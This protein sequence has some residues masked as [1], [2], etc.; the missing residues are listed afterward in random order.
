MSSLN[1][2]KPTDISLDIP[3][4]LL[5]QDKGLDFS[6]LKGKKLVGLLG[7]A[8]SGKDTVADYF[9]DNYGYK[10]IKFGDILKNTLN[11]YFREIVLEDLVNRNIPISF[12]EI[13]FLVEDDRIL[14]EKLRPYM[15]WLGETLRE[16]NGVHF[17]INK[18]IEKIGDAEKIIVADIRRD[19]ELDLF[20]NNNFSLNKMCN[21]F[22]A[23]NL[24]DSDKLKNVSGMTVDYDTR[25]FYV[26]QFGLE[27]KDEITMKTI[28]TANREWLIE[29]TLYIDSRIPNEGDARSKYIESVSKRLAGKHGLYV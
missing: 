8:K 28:E 14:K 13:D 7:I 1:L 27:D 24:L 29:D 6:V 16:K 12:S 5:V 18:A 26:N 17:W 15:I 19:A 20:R 4:A 10:K 2:P 22:G 21:S 23:A 9:V 11:S 25:L 3:E